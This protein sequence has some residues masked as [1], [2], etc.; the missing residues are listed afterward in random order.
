VDVDPP[1]PAEHCSCHSWL[2]GTSFGP[3]W[4]SSSPALLVPSS[5]PLVSGI[6]RDDGGITVN[7]NIGKDQTALT[8]P[9][10]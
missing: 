8:G 2:I 3:F 7:T 5:Q 6:R 9:N 10:S 1:V 4:P